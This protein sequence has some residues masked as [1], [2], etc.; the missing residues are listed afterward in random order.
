MAAMTGGASAME[1]GAAAPKSTAVGTEEIDF[2]VE[3]E[4]RGMKLVSSTREENGGVVLTLDLGKGKVFTL[5]GVPGRGPFCVSTVH[6]F[7]LDGLFVENLEEIQAQARRIQEVM[8]AAAE[9]YMCISGEGEGDDEEDGEDKY[10]YDYGGMEMEM[11]DEKAKRSF[12]TQEGGSVF[13]DTDISQMLSGKAKSGA[14][15]KSKTAS[16]NTR[17]MRDLSRLMRSDTKK[18]GFSLQLKNDDALHEWNINLFGFSDCPLAEDMKRLE[19]EKHLDHVRLM[20]KFKDDYPFSPPFVQ[21]VYPRFKRST[22]YIIDG[23][24]C[25]ELLTNQGWTPTNDI[26]SVVVQIRAQMVVGKA[27]IDFDATSVTQPYSEDR[28]KAAFRSA[29]KIH[30]WAISDP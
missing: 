12:P 16:A 3:A 11:D 1:T 8:S 29:A 26:E 23:A 20:M 9:V 10:E 18:L 6:P 19:K 25:M 4:N 17:L 14:G 22:G 28:A 13:E 5:S 27:R 30:K 7:L 15:A 2:A 24:F 21:I